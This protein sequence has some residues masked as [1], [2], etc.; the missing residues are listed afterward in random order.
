M[1]ET[2]ETLIQGQESYILYVFYQLQRTGIDYG[3]YILHIL[4]SE[5]FDKDVQKLSRMLM[6]S[7]TVAVC[8]LFYHETDLPPSFVQVSFTSSGPIQ[9]P[10]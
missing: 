7:V 6:I 4:V 2:L 10:K 8:R 1:H 9:S 3:G 5:R